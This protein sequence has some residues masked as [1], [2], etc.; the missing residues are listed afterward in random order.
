MYQEHM[1]GGGCSLHVVQHLSLS[2]EVKGDIYGLT[3]YPI[4]IYHVL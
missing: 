4:N 2:E 3:T 1:G